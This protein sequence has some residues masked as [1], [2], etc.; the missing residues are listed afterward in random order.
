MEGSGG[1]SKPSAHS[2][3]HLPQLPPLIPGRLRHRY[4][5]LRSQ[6]DLA[7]INH[8]GGGNVRDLSVPVQGV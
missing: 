3:H 7:V 6:N 4:H 1:D 8:E 5:H 2:L